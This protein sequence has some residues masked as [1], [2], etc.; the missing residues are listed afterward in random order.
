MISPNRTLAIA[1]V[2]IAALQTAVPIVIQKTTHV[3]VYSQVLHGA[4][5][6]CVVA[7]IVVAL[8][9]AIHRPFSAV[10]IIVFYIG[11]ALLVAFDIWI[12]RAVQASC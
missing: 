5:A 9:Q 2:V 4:I 7:V 3:I 6:L 8:C 11:L 10:A 12:E 1:F